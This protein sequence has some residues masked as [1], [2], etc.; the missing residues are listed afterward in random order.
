[1]GGG[2]L[3]EHPEKLDPGFE[4]AVKHSNCTA[5]TSLNLNIGNRNW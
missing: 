4:Y 5:H 3:R 1:M 2:L